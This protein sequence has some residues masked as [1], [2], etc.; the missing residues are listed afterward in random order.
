MAKRRT[1]FGSC[2]GLFSTYV[3]LLDFILRV[4]SYSEIREPG[5]FGNEY[6]KDERWKA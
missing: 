5:E 2:S 1:D 6:F 4:E 3:S